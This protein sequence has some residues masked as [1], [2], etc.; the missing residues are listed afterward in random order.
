MKY[1]YIRN[2]SD[3]L[4]WRRGGL[5]GGILEPPL[6]NPVQSP[7]SEWLARHWSLDRF[8]HFAQSTRLITE[9]ERERGVS[10]WEREKESSQP[11][12]HMKVIKSWSRAHKLFKTPKTNR[13]YSQTV[14]IL[15]LHLP[16]LLGFYAESSW[17]KARAKEFVDKLAQEI[18]NIDVV[19]SHGGAPS[20][21][22]LI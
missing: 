20:M 14:K 15:W 8:L 18:Y 6:W 12:L 7:S 17:W 2:C 11:P 22:R 9:R 5:C 16:V 19:S 10:E 3:E 4:Q 1:L 13:F 21:A